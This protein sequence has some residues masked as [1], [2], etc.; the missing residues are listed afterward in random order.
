[1]DWASGGGFLSLEVGK[2][3]LVTFSVELREEF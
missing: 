1:M 3:W 2:Q